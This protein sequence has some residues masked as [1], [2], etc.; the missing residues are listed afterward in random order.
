MAESRNAVLVLEYSSAVSAR[1]CWRA[2]PALAV[3]GL[4]VTQRARLEAV[5]ERPCDGIGCLLR[6]EDTRT[7]SESR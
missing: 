2:S 7:A 6:R 4:F 5:S 3:D 1:T